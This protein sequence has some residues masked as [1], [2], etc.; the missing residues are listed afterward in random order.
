MVPVS[1]YKANALRSALAS[2]FCRHLFCRDRT[3]HDSL[4]EVLPPTLLAQRFSV[5]LTAL[6]IIIHTLSSIFLPF[7][8]AFLLS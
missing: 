2:P 3:T 7:T 8:A 1:Y 6:Y 4:K 5:E